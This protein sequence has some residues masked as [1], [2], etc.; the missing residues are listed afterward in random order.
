MNIFSDIFNLPLAALWTAVLGEWDHNFEERTEERIPV[1]KIVL[2][3]RFQNYQ[4]DIGTYRVFNSENCGGVVSS[5]N[6]LRAETTRS[7]L[8]SFAALMK[9]SRP[10]KLKGTR[11]RAVC[12]PT[13]RLSYNETNV[14]IATGWG[15]DKE[16]GNLADKLLEVKIP[17]HDNAICKEKY[18]HSVSIRNGHLCAG[19]L[20]GS[21]GA[22]VV[23]YLNKRIDTRA[24][25]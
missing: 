21:S 24:V 17:V 10:V 6:I 12:L 1:E 3:E 14:C 25:R 5:N 22:C 20:D 13:K 11:I 4:H 7:T 9:L 23:S 15:R 16:D 18:G 19:H 8:F 2:H